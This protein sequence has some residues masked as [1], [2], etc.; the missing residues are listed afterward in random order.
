MRE[1]YG[2]IR[3]GVEPSSGLFDEIGAGPV[4]STFR[5][6]GGLVNRSGLVSAEEFTGGVRIAKVGDDTVVRAGPGGD[7]HVRVIRSDGSI[8][9]EFFAFSPDFLGG[10]FVG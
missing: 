8:M 9:H 1:I 5:P 2:L 6:D 7:P 3:T 4:V 10:V